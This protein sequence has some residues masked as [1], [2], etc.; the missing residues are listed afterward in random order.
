MFDLRY[1]AASLAAVFL[2]LIIGILVGVGIT[3]GGFVSS[4]ER[5]ALNAQVADLRDQRD[6]ARRHIT[7]LEQEEQAN[8]DFVEATYPALMA[9]RLRDKKIVLV[10]IGSMD[11]SVKTT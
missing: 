10:S 9:D 8:Q 11:P 3:R 7:E 2:A 5:G 6:T 1:H 4:A